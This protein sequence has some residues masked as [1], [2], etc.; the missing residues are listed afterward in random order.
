MSCGP[1]AQQEPDGLAGQTAAQQSEPTTMSPNNAISQATPVPAQDGSGPELTNTPLPSLGLDTPCSPLGGSPFTG[2]RQQIH[3]GVA[4]VEEFLSCYEE[5]VGLNF[6]PA[7]DVAGHRRLWPELRQAVEQY[8]GV[9]NAHTQVLVCLARQGHTN[10]DSR[11]L[12]FWQDFSNPEDYRARMAGY[13][14][15]ERAR[16]RELARPSDECAGPSG[17]YRAQAKAWRTEF[18][19]LME[20]EPDR[21]KPVVNSILRQAVEEPGIPHFLTLDRALPIPSIGDLPNPTPWPTP[22]P[23]PTM[24]TT[25][26]SSANTAG[27]SSDNTIPTPAPHPQGLAGC[28]NVSPFTGELRSYGWCLE[29][30]MKAAESLCAEVGDDQARQACGEEFASDWKD[31]VSRL[32]IGCA[33]IVGPDVRGKCGRQA[34]ESIADSKLVYPEVWA[35]VLTKVS[36]NEVVAAAYEK[37]IQC[38]AA[39]DKSFQGIDSRLLFAWQTQMQYI[40]HQEELMDWLERFTQNDRDLIEAV[41]VPLRQCAVKQGYYA[42]QDAAWLTEV[43]RLVEEEPGKAQPLLDWRILEL[44]EQ[45][46]VAFFLDPR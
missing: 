10:V 18:Q 33:A 23:L 6:H 43:R 28:S 39:T 31:Y 46:G 9:I 21:A 42:T 14:P 11:L 37:V 44:L 20:E 25:R 7:I 16:M 41:R 3:V 24:N 32:Y 8:P 5:M 2:E 27:A 13:T 29:A 1:V 22:T 36:K 40:F 17:Y 38:L 12:F 15:E 19:R 34:L 4:Y 30:G 35:E 45:P 26:A